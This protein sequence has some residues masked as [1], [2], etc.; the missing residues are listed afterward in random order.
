[1][2]IYTRTGDTGTSSLADGERV[3]KNDLRLE[4]YGTTDELSAQLA[5]RPLDAQMDAWLNAEHGATS[6][7]YAQLKQS[8][9]TGL[10][11]GWLCE[12]MFVMAAVDKEKD[13]QT[14]FCGAYP[15]A[16][17]IAWRASPTARD[18]FWL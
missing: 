7:T 3:L 18:T 13:R 8:C 10:K 11:E 15:S 14:Y 2:K 5:G 17:V 12:H 6:T 1:M 16:C 9:I 4:A